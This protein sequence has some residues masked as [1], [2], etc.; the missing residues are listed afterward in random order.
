MTRKNTFAAVMIAM[1]MASVNTFAQ[2]RAPRQA[3][4][5]AQREMMVGRHGDMRMTAPRT[6]HAVARPVHQ[7]MARPVH[8]APMHRLDRHGYLPGWHGHVRYLD[9]RWGYYRD[10]RWYW[11]DTYFAPDY[12]YAHPVAVFHPHFYGHDVAAAV[13]GVAAGIAVGALINAL[14]R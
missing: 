5:A 14:V 7:P 10:S 13:G 9:G 11:Y 6:T 1:M 3:P 8:Q 4:R 12:Y 2:P